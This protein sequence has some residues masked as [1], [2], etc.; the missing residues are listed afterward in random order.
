MKVRAFKDP[1]VEAYMRDVDR[2]LLREYLKLTPVERLEKFVRF[3][4]VADELRDGGRRPK[5][6]IS[7]TQHKIAVPYPNTYW[8]RPGQFLA[9]EHPGDLSEDIVMARLSG[10]LEAGIR[11]FINLTEE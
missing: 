10:L 8:V 1:V 7:I 11:T 6:K 2:T 5:K 4:K 9:G 3:A